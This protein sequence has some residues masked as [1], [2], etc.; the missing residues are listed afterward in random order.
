MHFLDFPRVSAVSRPKRNRGD[1]S[2]A[3]S[4]FKYLRSSSLLLAVGLTA[5]SE[6]ADPLTIDSTGSVG[7][8]VF[9]DR[10]GNNVPD[11]G[12]DVPG[13]GL[14]LELQHF[15]G[16]V[17]ASTAASLTG[18]ATFTSIP[19]GRYRVA[20]RSTD[21]GDTLRLARPDSATVMVTSAE[22]PP[23]YLPLS[24][25]PATAAQIQTLALGR[26]VTLEGVA[27]HNANIFGDSLLH[28]RDRTGVVRTS[29][30]PERMIGVTG[31]SVRVI[32]RVGI[33]AGRPALV[34]A[35]SFV[36]AKA[37]APAPLRVTTATA[38]SA[39]AAL[40]GTLAQI[41]NATVISVANL[42]T[43]D[44][45][46]RVSDGSGP[47]DVFVDRSTGI[48]NENP[49]VPGVILDVTGI[50][51]PKEG[52]AEW[53]LKPRVSLDLRVVIPSGTIAEVKNLP[54]GSLFAVTGIALNGLATFGDNTLFI[55]DSSGSLRVVN[56]TSAFIFA[57]DS[58][59][60]LGIV[61]VR[62]GQVVLTS[63]TTTVL[64]KSTVPAPQLIN[65]S[66]AATANGGRLDAALVE[67]RNAQVLAVTSPGLDGNL[68]VNDGSGPVVIFI[69]RDTGISASGFTVGERLNVTGLLAPTGTGTWVLLPRTPAD[70]TRP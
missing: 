35:A 7:V 13:A 2:S 38:V 44:T 65:T 19:V 52:T 53:M 56:V 31:D 5:C 54:T 11:N 61:A 50:L 1:Y 12:I 66:V 26:P 32:G 16:E 4:T 17:V 62:E 18:T 10:N 49:I 39:G 45:R 42:A 69:D 60:V 57:G 48:T 33:A 41:V 40:D 64:G 47:V 68:L 34:D 6:A 27:L 58:V 20:V 63:V 15:S 9:I 51:F 22:T 8:Q 59:R 3:F 55:R 30:P 14:R 36:I 25:P 67:I 37:N 24:Y 43:G 29:G 23:S 28:L 21:L 46:L 70:I